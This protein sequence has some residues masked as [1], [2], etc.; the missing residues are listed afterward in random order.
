[1]SAQDHEQRKP[2]HDLSNEFRTLRHL[3]SDIPIGTTDNKHPC[4]FCRGGQNGDRAF[5]ITRTSQIEAKY[6]CHRASCGKSGRIAATGFRLQ[7]TVRGD[8]VSP[9][10]EFTPRLYTG[11]TGQLDSEWLSEIQLH[12]GLGAEDA[13]WGNW[14]MDLGTKR[15][16]CPVLSPLGVVRGYETRQSKSGRS[17]GS[18]KTKSYRQVDGT[19]MGW[20]RRSKSG[21]VVLIEDIISGLKVSRHAQAGVLLGS[22]VSLDHVLEAVEVAGDEPVFLA[23]DRD[24]LDKAVK[25]IRAN[26]FIAPNFQFVPVSK[27]LKYYNDNE[28]R[29]ICGHHS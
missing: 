5:S 9:T 26:R 19:W 20:F 28:I 21:P 13:T 18:L 29:S 14:V 8:S 2:R 3:V 24:A 27:D 1:M 23:L 6:C 12:Y 11:D 7:Q 17:S 16:V 15:L 25:F 22:H 10:R 4:P